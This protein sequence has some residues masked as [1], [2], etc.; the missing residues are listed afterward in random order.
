MHMMHR[1]PDSEQT[2]YGYIAFVQE[3]LRLLPP[4]NVGHAQGQEPVEV[5]QAVLTI[6]RLPVLVGSRE[7]S[8]W[9]DPSRIT[10]N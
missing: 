10:P 4:V 3:A 1:Q 2:H 5:N 6:D 8:V 9:Q 7:R